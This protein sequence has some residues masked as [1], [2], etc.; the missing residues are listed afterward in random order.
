[1]TKDY[2]GTPGPSLSDLQSNCTF[3][4]RSYCVKCRPALLRSTNLAT[5]SCLAAPS[6]SVMVHCKGQ[7]SIFLDA[8]SFG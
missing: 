5:T 4:M 8:A 7:R 3:A 1:M 2:A 6:G